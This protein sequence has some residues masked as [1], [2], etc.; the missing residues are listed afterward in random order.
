[1]L[2]E[3]GARVG[4]AVVDLDLLHAGIAF[5]VDEVVALEEVLVHF[6]GAADVEDGVGGAD[7]FAHPL[8]G[9]AGGREALDE[10]GA[11]APFALE[12]EA[13][14]EGV[15]GIGGV[16]VVGAGVEGDR[17]IRQPLGVLDVI[18]IVP[19]PEQ[20][21]DVV[22]VLPDHPRDG[23]AGHE[24]HDDDAFS[25]HAGFLNRE[26]SGCESICA[27]MLLLALSQYGTSRFKL[28]RTEQG[29]NIHRPLSTG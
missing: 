10:A 2:A 17:L 1:M 20:P 18:H 19:Q 3:V 11:E 15:E 21:D 7:E 28:G 22:D 8:E 4:V 14:R 26:R 5:E 12:A 25:L 9:E 16:A 6:L 23:N 24:A 29:K 27:E 13:A